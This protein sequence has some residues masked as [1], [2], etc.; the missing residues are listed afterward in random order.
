M[1]SLHLLNFL[2]YIFFVKI[3]TS[4]SEAVLAEFVPFS[5]PKLTHYKD[6]DIPSALFENVAHQLEILKNKVCVFLSMGAFFYI[7][8]LSGK[9][10]IF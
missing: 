5:T 7:L 9:L 1:I 2:L 6:K 8:F 3:Y 10:F 4:V